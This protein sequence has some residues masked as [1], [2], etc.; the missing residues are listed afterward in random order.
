M[1]IS[2]VYSVYYYYSLFNLKLKVKN[3]HLLNPVQFRRIMKIVID[4]M[5]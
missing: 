3:K 4:L 5:K 1:A 2:N